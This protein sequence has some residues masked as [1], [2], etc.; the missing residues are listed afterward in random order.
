MRARRHTQGER[1]TPGV[2]GGRVV[3][4]RRVLEPPARYLHLGARGVRFRFG[5]REL[6]SYAEGCIL[7]RDATPERVI[8][9]V[10][11]V[12]DDSVAELPIGPCPPNAM[13][14]ERAVDAAGRVSLR[15]RLFDQFTVSID[16]DGASATVRYPSAALASYL[17]DDVLQAA[18]QPMVQAENGFVLHGACVARGGDA[19]VLTAPS[20]C[21]KSTTAFNF[22]R[23]GYD[24][25]ADD[26]VLVTPESDGELWVWPLVRE[27]SLRTLSFSLLGQ[28]RNANIPYR[29]DN[30][31]YLVRLRRPAA[32]GAILRRLC[33]L[34]VGGE[35]TTAVTPLSRAETRAILQSEDRHF[36]YL[37]RPHR[38][39]YAALLS[40]RVPALQSVRLGRDLD[41]QVRAIE[42]G[43]AL[44]AAPTSPAAHGAGRQAKLALIR[45]AWRNPGREP[46]R[47]L[48]PLIGD[49]DVA[50]LQAAIGFLN[51][52][53]L[54][55]LEPLE[56]A[57]GTAAEVER[58]GASG[59]LQWLRVDDWAEGSRRL[60]ASVAPEV[61]AQFAEAWLRSAPTLLPF[62]RAAALDAA[63]RESID[64]AWSRCRS[65][66]DACVAPTSRVLVD[67]LG[68]LNG[69]RSAPPPGTGAGATVPETHATFL[70]I[71]RRDSAGWSELL[72]SCEEGVAV[73]VVPVFGCDDGVLDAAVECVRRATESGMQARLSRWMPLCA[74]RDDDARHLLDQRLLAGDGG[75]GPLDHPF[76]ITVTEEIEA[77]GYVLRWSP[78]AC[79]G[80]GGS[81]GLLGFCSGGGFT[82]T[83]R[84]PEPG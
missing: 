74:L 63:D 41:G 8:G 61:I 1:K 36:P 38:A 71:A 28:G 17:V 76:A 40:E 5:D 52:Y 35:A 79:R 27:V 18:L 24:L 54:A 75:G 83:R 59:R 23:H 66:G 46:L 80:A 43:H 77:A 47:E 58:A 13:R 56:R 72:A 26:A 21:G 64:R 73:T 29:T 81:V 33:F 12:R 6:A 32:P 30:G 51:H 15:I 42:D 20:G 2:R 39:P 9:E 67:A 62:L 22:Y 65:P 60:C 68:T 84:S 10:T 14:Y 78:C 48:L 69:R 16:H 82:L 11:Y 7:L 44:V 31:K 34:A 25:Y 57:A 49:G 3:A 70:G 45:D 55:Q 37:L 4:V 50:V 19:I 53:P